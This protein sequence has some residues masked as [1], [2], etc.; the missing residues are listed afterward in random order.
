M[1]CIRF[2]ALCPP[3]VAGPTVAQ[4][5]KPAEGAP[6]PTNIRGARNTRLHDDLRRPSASSAARTHR[7]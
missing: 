6:A 2:A 3:V 4:D 7:R 1:N 5:L